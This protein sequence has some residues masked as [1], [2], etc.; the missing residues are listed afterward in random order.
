MVGTAGHVD[1]GKTAL[2]EA[3]TGIDTDR[4][5]EEKRR[6]ITIELGFAHLELAGHV[7]GVV[8]VPGH[9]RF[10]RAMVAGASGVDVVLLV[11]AADEGVMPQTREHLQ[12]CRLLGVAHGLVAL[13]KVDL[14]DEDW[15]ELVAADVHDELAGS[16][17][18]QARIIRF[19][20]TDP[21]LRAAGVAALRAE[22]ERLARLREDSV[23]PGPLRV[24]VDRVFTVRGFGTVVTGT[25]ASG[26]VRVG[27]PVELLP[28]GARGRVRGLQVHGEPWHEA[29]RGQRVALNLQGLDREQIGRGEVVG[30]VGELQP[31]SMI[32]V[33]LELLPH[34]KEPLG[35][36]ARLLLHH[37]T[38]Q[39]QARVVLLQDE[40]LLPGASAWAQL[41][42]SEPLVALP[43]DRF[44]LRG[45]ARDDHHG[46][47]VGGG[48]V[49]L[50]HP[51]RRRRRDWAAACAALQRVQ[52]GGD[53]ALLEEVLTAAGP[54]GCLRSEL[55]AL[56][57]LPPA[58]LTEHLQALIAS[59][60]TTPCPS[61]AGLLLHAS[62][63]DAL[64]PAV[65]AV[66][67]DHHRRK[68]R[69]AGL[70][71]E[72][73]LS[74]VAALRHARGAR[75]VLARWIDQGRLRQTGATV[76]LPDFCP[77]A[78]PRV[79]V[80]KR[81]LAGGL[82]AAGLT[83]PRPGELAS[84][85]SRPTAEV[86]ELLDELVSEGTLARVRDDF[87]LDAEALEGLRE[88]LVQ[89]LTVHETITPGEFKGLVGGSRRYTIPLAEHFDQTKL[90]LRVG[91]ARRLRRAPGHG[92]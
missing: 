40:P 49:V 88:R 21:E 90:T 34:L 8:D 53:L 56:T 32:D 30:A 35:Q 11:V 82:R 89:H 54:R 9:E 92:S 86:V 70:E 22:L 84:E 58:T 74:R 17:L 71:R 72:E 51:P 81:E 91:D 4:L 80:L 87:Y 65:L 37:G 63:G 10:V 1:H 59:D 28:S 31:C 2:V 45:F 6:G 73:L 69:R 7:L 62:A 38:R 20:A 13:T 26:A 48:R 52:Q 18:Q 29:G 67:S 57:G 55:V 39:A 42:L 83:P 77:S 46:A 47:T 76:A 43:G 24:P 5:Q 19:S 44:I 41:R 61:D 78:D 36:G 79:D 15:L 66:L 3:L 64:L 25:C 14:V 16:P 12:I 50:V 68:P 23:A 33:R 85:R 75:C 27:Q 60:R